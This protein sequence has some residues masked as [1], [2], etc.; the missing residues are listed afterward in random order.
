MD[1]K[2]PPVEAQALLWNSVTWSL[3]KNTHLPCDYGQPLR[4]S[5][6]IPKSLKWK[7]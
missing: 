2:Q 5:A 6:P 3:R 7:Y 4:F 1:P